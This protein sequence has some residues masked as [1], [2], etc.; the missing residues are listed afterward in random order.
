M[1]LSKIRRSLLVMGSA[2]ITLASCGGTSYAPLGEWDPMVWKTENNAKNGNNIPAA[3]GE[4]TFIC[5]NYYPW[6][7]NA[8]SNGKHYLPQHEENSL[9]PHTLTTEWAKAEINGNKLKVTFD[10]NETGMERQLKLEVTGGDI[11]HAFYFEQSA[12]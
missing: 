6:I 11:F 2:A 12:N 10:A 8:E 9:P 4:L 3:G 5:T 1:N 7:E